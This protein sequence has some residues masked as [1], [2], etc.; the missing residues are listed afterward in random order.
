[1]LRYAYKICFLLYGVLW[2]ECDTIN[3]AVVLT[4]ETFVLSLE[5]PL[6]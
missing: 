3:V 5:T 4:E 1:M 2:C 6:S